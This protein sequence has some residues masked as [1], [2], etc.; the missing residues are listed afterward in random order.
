M[1]KLV[2]APFRLPV[3]LLLVLNT[4]LL[5][6]IVFLLAGGANRALAETEI[7]HPPTLHYQGR[8]LDPISGQPKVDGAYSMLF[9]IYNQASGGSPLWSEARSVTISKGIFSARLGETSVLNTSLFDGQDLWLGLSVG[10]D[11]EMTPR[12]PLLYVP[13][14]VYAQN[15]KTLNGQPSSS[16]APSTHTHS[17]LPLGYGAVNAIGTLVSGAYNVS[18]VT[19]NASLQRYEIIFGGSFSYGPS[20][21]TTATLTGDTG[22]C[23]A[24]ATIRQSSV[25]GKLLVYVV[26]S[27]GTKIQCAFRFISFGRYP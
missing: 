2:L 16:F 7:S 19:W 8:L 17:T 23:P 5:A 10:A 3:H 1:K 12:Q 26:N 27:A 6:V 11:P 15:A 22:S 18:N 14:A 24:G 13:Y 9:S 21:T 4:V 25:D 20:D